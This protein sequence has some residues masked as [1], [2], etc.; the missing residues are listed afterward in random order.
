MNPLEDLLKALLWFR[1]SPYF[2][3][4]YLGIMSLMVAALT[5]YGIYLGCLSILF[6][7]VVMFALPYWLKERRIKHFALNGLVIFVAAALIFAALFAQT[8]SG[9]DPI[10]VRATGPAGTTLRNATVLPGRGPPGAMYTFTANLTVPGAA[11]VTNY[12]VY[13][14][15]TTVDGAARRLQMF[16]ANPTD[17]N[18]TDGKRYNTSVSVDERIYIFWFFVTIKNGTSTTWF[19]SPWQVGPITAGYGTFYQFTL[20]YGVFALI[21]PIS[22]YF[23]LLMLFWWTTR[24]RMERQRLGMTGPTETDTGFMCTNCGADVPAAA[25]KCPKCGAVFEE[26]RAGASK[27]TEGEKERGKEPKEEPGDDEPG[28][29]EGADGKP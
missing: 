20:Y 16:E 21:L 13:V 17:W 23:I 3:I 24:A 7:A 26:A 1:K 22:L 25:D 28:A 4:F 12:A 29:V 9:N 2:R 18:L 14:N 10:Q 6:S 11:N 5:L 19:E 15:L 8:L 27:E